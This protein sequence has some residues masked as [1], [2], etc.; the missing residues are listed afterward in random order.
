METKQVG[1]HPVNRFTP[2]EDV[3]ETS[4]EHGITADKRC[5]HCEGVFSPATVQPPPQPAGGAG[6]LAGDG[7]NREAEHPSSIGLSVASPVS[8][9]EGVRCVECNR[10]T[11]PYKLDFRG[12]CPMCRALRTAGLPKPCARCAELEREREEITDGIFSRIRGELTLFVSEIQTRRSICR[13]LAKERDDLKARN[14]ALEQRLLTICVQRD[15][16]I[17][18]SD[19]LRIK[20]DDLKAKVEKAE[21]QGEIYR[22]ETHRWKEADKN[23]TARIEVLEK[24]LRE[25]RDAAIEL[26]DA[27]VGQGTAGAVDG[28]R[29]DAAHSALGLAINLADAALAGGK[30]TK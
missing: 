18:E 6:D 15:R 20:R 25:I 9:I 1:W 12:T 8:V 2:R 3:M 13:T 14:A 10:P 30:E 27:M 4:C 22:Q 16:L 21:R 23:A 11:H 17:G 28:D 19:L 26:C 7:S 29:E 5:P 24:A